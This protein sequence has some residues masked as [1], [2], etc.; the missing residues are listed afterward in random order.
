MTVDIAKVMTYEIRKEIA[1]RYFGFRKL[2]EEDKYEL[3]RKI[4]LQTMTIEQ[5][6]ALDLARIYYI[7]QDRALIERFLDLTGLENAL[8]FDEYMISSPTIRARIFAGVKAK[9]LTRAGRFKNLLLGC[10][11]LLVTH[12]EE[13][14]VK[15]REILAEREEIDEEIKLFYKKNDIGNILG[16][17]RGL[18]SDGN[19]SLKGPAIGG[20]AENL[21]RKLKVDPPEPVDQTLP[22]IPPLVHLSLIR[23]EMKELAEAAM[24]RHAKGFTRNLSSS[25]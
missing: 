25:S 6:I 5:R 21:D 1:E 4:H 23:R 2:I 18:D 22:S 7:L 3:A 19:E 17:L 16:F 14:R 8:F 11:D 15:Y 20:V 13:Y 24:T 12:V 9:G 10:Y